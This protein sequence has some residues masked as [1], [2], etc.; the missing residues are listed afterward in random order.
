MVPTGW[1]T[2]SSLREVGSPGGVA[3]T[4]KAPPV[5]ATAIFTKGDGVVPWESCIDHETPNVRHVEVHT[6]HLGLGLHHRV[7]VEVAQ[8]LARGAALNRP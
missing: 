5:P 4:V 8:A 1:A 3:M 7:F 2:P 6:T